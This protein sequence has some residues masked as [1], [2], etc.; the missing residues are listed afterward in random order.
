MYAKNK[1]YKEKS[2]SSKDFSASSPH[3]QPSGWGKQFGSLLVLNFSS[4][5]S[6]PGSS[7]L[8]WCP[9]LCYVSP[10]FSVRR[11]QCWLRRQREALPQLEERKQGSLSLPLPSPFPSLSCQQWQ[12]SLLVHIN[13]LID[14]WRPA[15]EGITRSFPLQHLTDWVLS[16]PS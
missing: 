13:I 9:T 12:K 10:P 2:N 7:T 3:H 14:V 5:K 1:D 8:S 16:L 15:Q 4:V 11:L 6:F